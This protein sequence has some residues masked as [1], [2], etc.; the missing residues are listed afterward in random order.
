MI[1]DKN[2]KH[3]IIKIIE[4]R[5]HDPFSI[6]GYHDSD[7]KATVRAFLPDTEHASINDKFT[8]T[9]VEG[10]DFFY[11]NGEKT[12]IQWPYKIH[13]LTHAGEQLSLI[14]I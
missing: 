3:D 2:L 13:R 12:D 6:L 8:M 5:H 11:W 4:A 1:F 9:R 7:N 10:T 14:H